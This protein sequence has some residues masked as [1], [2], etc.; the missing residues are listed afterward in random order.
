MGSI[1]EYRDD[2]LP[3]VLW[4]T[5]IVSPTRSRE[6]CV[7]EMV[8]VGNVIVKERKCGA[9]RS[10]TNVTTYCYKVCKVCGFAVKRIMRDIPSEKDMESVRIEFYGGAVTRGWEY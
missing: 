4:P 7:R 10:R 1:V 6:C 9:G 5:R 3:V 2:V 8:M